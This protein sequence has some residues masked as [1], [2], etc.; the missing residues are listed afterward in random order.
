MNK[1]VAFQVR[2]K[3]KVFREVDVIGASA[4]ANRMQQFKPYVIIPCNADI[5][6]SAIADG[7]N[8][9]MSGTIRGY[10]ASVI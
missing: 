10:L 7:A 1:E 6:L 2:E 8:T 4:G 9:D 5:R 3:G